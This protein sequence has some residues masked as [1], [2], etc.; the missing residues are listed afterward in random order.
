MTLKRY[1]TKV[2]RVID[3]DV[4]TDKFTHEVMDK[5]NKDDEIH[6]P[7]AKCGYDVEKHIARIAE[8]VSLQDQADIEQ[9]RLNFSDIYGYLDK[10][11]IRVTYVDDPYCDDCDEV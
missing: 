9:N 10:L 1:T 11:G 5:V 7:L 2:T 8:H 6:D 4:D 3:F